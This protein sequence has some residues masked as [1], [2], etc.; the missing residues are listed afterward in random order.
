MELISSIKGIQSIGLL[1]LG[2]HRFQGQLHQGGGRYAGHPPWLPRLHPTDG[3]RR[4]VD[5]AVRA[6]RH[7][8]PY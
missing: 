3:A 2:P 1:P 6:H 7:A 5:H 8:R 4:S